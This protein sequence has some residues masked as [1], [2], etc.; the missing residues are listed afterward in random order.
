MQLAR[1]AKSG[2]ENT[3]IRLA[4][5][6][7]NPDRANNLTHSQSAKSTPDPDVDIWRNL[8]VNYLSW[9]IE[10]SVAQVPVLKFRRL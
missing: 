8:D 4:S 6:P 2:V 3:I 1:Q 9:Q 10:L 7:A 5:P